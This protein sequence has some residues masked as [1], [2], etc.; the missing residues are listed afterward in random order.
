MERAPLVLEAR[1]PIPLDQRE[2]IEHRGTVTGQG[3]KIAAGLGVPA[4]EV[5]GH[6][7]RVRPQQPVNVIL[8]KIQDL[9]RYAVAGIRILGEQPHLQGLD[10]L[11]RRYP[12]VLHA[13]ILAA[14]KARHPTFGSSGNSDAGVRLMR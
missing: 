8:H 13:Q 7:D 9:I 12:L 2:Q 3:G 14:T 5:A 1:A 10:R 11:G 4:Q 6:L